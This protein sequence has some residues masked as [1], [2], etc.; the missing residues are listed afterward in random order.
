MGKPSLT[1]IHPPS[2]DQI[3]IDCNS[4]EK[5]SEVSAVN[6]TAYYRVSTDRQGQSGLGLEAQQNAV[7]V[8]IRTKGWTLVGEYTEVESGK[9]KDRPMLADA[10]AEAKRLKGK[11][12][13][14]KLDR[15][16]RNVHFISGLMETGVDFVAVDMPTA[17][18]FML[19]VYAAMAEEEGRRI[20]QRTKAALA[21]AKARGVELGANGKVLAKAHIAAAEAYAVTL[22]P[23][24]TEIRNEGHRSVRA[25]TAALN[26]RDIPSREGGRW[27]LKSTWLLLDRLK[28][29]EKEN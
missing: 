4:Q 3:A 19:H 8:F 6:C 18:R 28:L 11:L 29:T 15:L 13:I 23:T 2:K 12:V 25:I 27:H 20:S 14:A 16:A 17:D 5:P 22:L 24:I 7:A 26:E 10:I 21:A 1:R 9:R